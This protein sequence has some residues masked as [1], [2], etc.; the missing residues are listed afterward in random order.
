ME[1][2]FKQSSGGVCACG[3]KLPEWAIKIGSLFCGW[4][5]WKIDRSE[6]PPRERYDFGYVDDEEEE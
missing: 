6:K 2:S 1:E 4:C 3:E 5:M